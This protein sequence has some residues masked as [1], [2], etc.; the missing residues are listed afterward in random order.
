MIPKN[1][2]RLNEYRISEFSDGHLWWDAYSGFGTQAGGQCII[3]GNILFMG[4]KHGEE[5]GFLIL[6]FLDSLKKLPV[7]NRTRYYCFASSF[8]DVATGRNICEDRLQQLASLPRKAFA[9]SQ[10]IITDKPE[11]FRLGQYQISV[12]P[13]GDI[14]WKSYGGMNRVVGGTVLIESDVLFIGPRNY[15]DPQRNKREFLL[16]FHLLPKWDR[17]TLWCRG[18]VLNSVMSQ[19][20]N[21]LPISP[22]ETE[23]IAQKPITPAINDKLEYSKKIWSQLT[24][25]YDECLEEMKTGWPQKVWP[26]RKK[27]PEIKNKFD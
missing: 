12:T 10:A 22:L 23:M 17:T 21:P 15:D 19:R 11:T 20:E 6:E 13:D 8:L 25:Y 2:Y 18:L 9:R 24:G 1:V 14:S 4:A 26:K 7:W 16:T 27:P 3:Y 5:D